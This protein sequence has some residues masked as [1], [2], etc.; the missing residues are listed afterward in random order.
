MFKYFVLLC[1]DTIKI[2]I[3]TV[4]YNKSIYK[5]TTH[6]VYTINNATL[7]P[8]MAAFDFDWTLVNPKEGRTFPKNVDDWVWMYSCIPEKI[9][10]YHQKGYMIVVFTNQSKL[11]KHEQIKIAMGSLE[12]PI[13]VVVAMK[14]D[15]YK[16]NPKLLDD[17]L[18]GEAISKENSFFVGDALGRKHDHSDCDLEFAKNIGIKCYTPEEMFATTPKNFEI[19]T[20]PKS[21]MP[22]VIIMVGYPGSG[23]STIA[24]HICSDE[25]YKHIQGDVYKT[26]SKMRKAAKPF[27]QESKSIVF[28]A[29]HSSRK[30][31]KEL[32]DFAKKFNYK[33]RCIH[34]TT[35]F[36]TS[37]KRNK[38]RSDKTQVPKIAYSVYKK[39][40]EEPQPEEGFSLIKI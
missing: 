22:E 6:A 24:A 7:K 38:L 18:H 39:Y 21:D 5:M 26:S 37:Y 27:M 14:K 20:I 23:K 35:S 8:N 34:M 33:V 25:N 12:I 31:R 13:W 28:D 17:L 36:D 11:W 30:K 40:F 1:L 9:K 3:N 19:Q 15:Y 29:T 2:E 32:I 4:I 16:P 10:E